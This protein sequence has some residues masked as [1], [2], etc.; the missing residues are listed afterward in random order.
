MLVVCAL[1]LCAVCC[2]HAEDEYFPCKYVEVKHRAVDAVSAKAKALASAFR[3]AFLDLLQDHMKMD[4]NG[5]ESVSCAVSD[6]QVFDCVYDYSVEHEKYSDSFYMAEISCR[7]SRK[8]VSALLESCGI[9]MGEISAKGSSL[10]R[11][12]RNSDSG[13]S[14]GLVVCLDDFI[15]H[16]QKLNELGCR[17]TKFSSLVVAFLLD[18]CHMSEFQGIGIKYAHTQ[19]Q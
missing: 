11:I 10:D 16:F 8:N 7:F 5:A 9:W 12:D 13:E 2:L 6:G 18:G 4:K 17:V 14:V 3:I 19:M 15:C 1:F